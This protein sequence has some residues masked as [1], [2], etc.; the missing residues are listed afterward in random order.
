MS[1]FQE[2]EINFGTIRRGK[3]KDFIFQANTTIPPIKEII[4]A[5]GCTKPK[6]NPTTRQLVVTYK[7]GEIPKHITGNQPIS[8]SITVFYTDG[9]HEVLKITGTKLR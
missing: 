9:S 6:Y 3:S 2:T 4:A 5:C 1:H 8:K 7:A